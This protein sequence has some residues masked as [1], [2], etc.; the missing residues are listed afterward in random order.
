MSGTARLHSPVRP[1]GFLEPSAVRFSRFLVSRV[2]VLYP[3]F[4]SFPL[5]TR[6]VD[7]RLV[8]E[9]PPPRLCST[10]IFYQVF[11]PKLPSVKSRV[12]P[13]KLCP[14]HDVIHDLESYP[15][16]YDALYYPHY[17]SHSRI[18]SSLEMFYRGQ[19]WF[20]QLSNYY[21]PAAVVALRVLRDAITAG[22]QG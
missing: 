15:T 17:P 1:L 6:L 14:P 4:L 12:L 2:P 19:V 8:G 18:V 13:Y 5:E 20:A 21:A 10:R 3:A 11:I 7:G 22:F 16:Y 9:Y